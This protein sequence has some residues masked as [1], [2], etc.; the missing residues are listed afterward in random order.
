[1]DRPK[2]ASGVLLTCPFQHADHASL[3]HCVWKHSEAHP[4][5]VPKR[6]A[7]IRTSAVGCKEGMA[8]CFPCVQISPLAR[9][10][11]FLQRQGLLPL[12]ADSYW[13]LPQEWPSAQ[14][15]CLTWGSPQLL[16]QRAENSAP[17]NSGQDLWRAM[18]TPNL[19]LGSADALFVA[20]L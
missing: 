19:P 13:V 9:Q 17:L 14:E 6:G 12:A 11:P 3:G 1:M 15:G 18:P 20:A 16:L 10:H 8:A 4:N 5:T 2:G 7:S